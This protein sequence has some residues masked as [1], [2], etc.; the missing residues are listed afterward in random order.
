MH[1]QTDRVL[2]LGASRNGEWWR[3]VWG[4]KSD[5]IELGISEKRLQ[6]PDSIPKQLPAFLHV[7]YNTYSLIGSSHRF[8]KAHMATL[9]ES[10]QS[11]LE[12]KVAQ[13]FSTG[14]ANTHGALQTELRIV[15]ATYSSPGVTGE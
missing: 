3:G 9:F 2:P 7:H 15:A 14:V 12:K 8:C 10:K 1:Q 11:A 5:R 6:P 13:L 4:V